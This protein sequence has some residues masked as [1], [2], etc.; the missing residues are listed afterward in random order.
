MWQDVLR[1]SRAVVPAEAALLLV[2]PALAS[3]V[4]LYGWEFAAA[5]MLALLLHELGHILAARILRLPVTALVFVPFFGAFV[6]LKEPPR[7]VEQASFF[8]LGG[9]AAGALCAVAC[10]AGWLCTG[11][12]FLRLLAVVGGVLN[13]VN[14]I[15]MF[16]LDGGTI[17]AI[18]APR[19]FRVAGAPLW[20]LMLWKHP[21][22][23]LL[24]LTLMAAAGIGCALRR[25]SDDREDIAYY[26]APPLD[27]L[28]AASAYLVTVLNLVLALLMAKPH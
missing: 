5:L 16:P 21:D 2:P 20:G 14:L 13:L 19:L 22:W 9:P 11:Y 26:A 4:L 3:F 10:A 1:A 25:A 12:G 15:P 6:L 28:C 7:T 18:L 8:A 17:L 27:R 23:S 24:P